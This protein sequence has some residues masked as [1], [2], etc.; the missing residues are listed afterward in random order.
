MAI[1]PQVEDR[2]YS[3][4]VEIVKAACS[5]GDYGITAI[6]NLIQAVY[7]KLIEIKESQPNK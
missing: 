5:S 3:D 6:T 7:D 4:T 1:L 2:V